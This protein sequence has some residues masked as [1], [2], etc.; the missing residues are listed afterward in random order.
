MKLHCLGD[1][2]LLGR[3]AVAVVGSRQMSDYGKWVVGWVVP[4]LVRR[5]WVVVSGMAL[6][7][8]AESHKVCLDQG[9]KT[10]AVLA[11]GVDVVSP[12]SNQ[13]IYERVL[14]EGG[15]IV[16]AY[17]NGSQPKPERFLQRN[18]VMAQLVAGV[19]VVEGARR[20]GTLV[21]AKYALDLGKEVWA[22][23]GRISDENSWTPNWLID[24][25]ARPLV[26]FEDLAL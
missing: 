22:V 1:K 15:L 23:P 25:G 24:R 21:T 2:T 18:R 20:S 6:G 4:E 10:M 7:V 14:K 16:S 12:K 13:W 8:D 5:G 17:K 26:D 19:I 9:G 3:P 11:S